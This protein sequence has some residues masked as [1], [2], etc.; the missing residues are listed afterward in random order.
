M[1]TERQA[2]Q[3]GSERGVEMQSVGLGRHDRG[4]EWEGRWGGGGLGRKEGPSCLALSCSGCLPALYC[5]VLLE[6]PLRCTPYLQYALCW[7][8]NGCVQ[9]STSEGMAVPAGMCEPLV[10]L[11]VVPLA[12][13][14]FAL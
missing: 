4:G 5:T 10:P 6:V 2:S 8:Q 3:R 9:Q 11:A 1:S 12:V 14:Y 7:E 13:L